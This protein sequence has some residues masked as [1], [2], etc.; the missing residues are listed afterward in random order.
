MKKIVKS[1]LLAVYGTKIMVLKKISK[2]ITYTLPGG[3]KKRKETEVEALIRE[4]AE[5]TSLE[6]M[7]EQLQFYLS[8]IRQTDI[9]TMNKN[10]YYTS[11]EP[12][13]IEVLEK[14]KFESVLWLD[15][16]QAIRFMDKSDRTAIKAYFKNMGRNQE[17]Q[18]NYER[19]V[20]PRIAL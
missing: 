7:E 20:S 16:K 2:S 9:R 3:I 6:L 8:L 15:W 5:E 18:E 19:Q 13:K 1:R 17:N 4:T 14:D 10:Y 11:L 12:L